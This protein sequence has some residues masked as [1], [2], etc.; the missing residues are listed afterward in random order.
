MKETKLDRL[1]EAWKVSFQPERGAPDLITL[2]TLRRG[3]ENQIP[4]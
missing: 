3:A 4:E 1:K 2:E